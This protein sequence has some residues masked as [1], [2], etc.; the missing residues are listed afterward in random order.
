M[1]EPSSTDDRTWL[2]RYE[3][4]PE[5]GWNPAMVGLGVMIAIAILFIGSI[6]VVVLD[7]GLETTAGRSAAQFVVALALGG[8][9]LGFALHGGGGNLREVPARLGLGR[10]GLAAVGLAAF[11]WA[12]YL[13]CAVLL[14]PLLAPEQ[15]DVTRA[16][17]TDTSSVIGVTVAALLIVVAAP[18]SEELFFRGFMFVGLR[19]R[20]SLWPAA[21]ISGAVWGSLHLGG[22]NIGVAIQLAVFGVILAWLYERSGTLWAPII[23][24]FVNNGIAFI[25]LTT[26]VLDKLS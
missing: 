15:Q 13:V 7:P 19:R 23:A 17:G 8:T 18:L 4:L 22:G 26:D 14:S 1:S 21:L 25:L 16:L 11:A 6:F 12:A 9:A 5:T 24:H 2:T 20:I 3:G 10:F